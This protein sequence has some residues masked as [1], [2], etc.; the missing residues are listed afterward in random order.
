LEHGFQ[1][2]KNLPDGKPNPEYEDMSKLGSGIYRSEDGGESWKYM[3]RHNR[4]PFYY[5]HIYINPFDD[6]LIYVLDSDFKI[7]RD[8][9]KT[10]TNLGTN[11]YLRRNTPVGIHGDSHAMWFDPTNKK[12]FYIGDDGGVALTHDHGS[13]IFFDNFVVSQFYAISVDMRDPYWVYGG[14]QDH[15]TWGGPSRDRDRGILT[16]HWFRIFGGD[17]F[18]TQVDPTDWRTLYFESQNGSISRMNVET[19]RAT[20]IRPRSNNI[21]NYKEYVIK[22][23]SKQQKEKGWGNNPFRF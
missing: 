10:L 22:E 5:S 7:S 16:D 12:R 15:A 6:K 23:I 18:H 4:R 14:L 21:V 19:R 2:Q 8:G 9:G 17:G 13:Y 3:N 1:P 20:F 11:A